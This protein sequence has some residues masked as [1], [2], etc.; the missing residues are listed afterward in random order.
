MRAGTAVVEGVHVDPIAIA[1]RD[2]ARFS[3][4]QLGTST[5]ED[6][7]TAAG[8]TAEHIRAL[9]RRQ[10]GWEGGDLR[11]LFREA[12]SRLAP[13]T[14]PSSGSSPVYSF[15]WLAAATRT[16]K[17]LLAHH[18]SVR[19]SRGYPPPGTLEWT[20]P[21]VELRLGDYVQPVPGV[22]RRVVNMITV[23]Q[24]EGYSTQYGRLLS[25]HGTS[26][27]F[28]VDPGL[29]ALWRPDPHAPGARAG[30]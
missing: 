26:K 11:A 6:I 14:L 21:L 24:G 20:V 10:R 13:E 5:A 1:R 27:P 22:Y 29:V 23:R 18:D 7:K 9:M 4:M 28:K 3:S 8:R 30:S 25:L 12:N 15:R 17:K 16:G 2:L 19:G